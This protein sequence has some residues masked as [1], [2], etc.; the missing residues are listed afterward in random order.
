MAGRISQSTIETVRNSSDIIS[1]IGEYTKLERRA[2]NDYWG[3]CP[4]H[5]EKTASFHVDTDK[6]FYYCFGCHEHGDV[7]KFVMDM[8]KVSY[9]DAVTTL[10]RKSGITVQYEDGYVPTVKTDSVKLEEYVDLYERTASMFHYLLMETEMG[11]KGLEYIK[12]RGL[13]E[14]TIKKFKLGY[15]PQDRYWLHGFLKSKNYSD[16]FLAKSG[17][18]SSKYPKVTL[19]SDRLMFPIFNRNGKA[20]AFSGRVLHEQREGEGKYLNSPELP[21]YKKRETLFCFNFAKNSIRTNK[22]VIICEGNM[23]CIAYHQSGIDYAVAPLGTAFTDDQVKILQGF[24]DTIL[25]SFDSDAA[26]QKAT[27]KAI[28]M[29]RRHGLTVKIIQLKGGKDPA[30][31]LLNFGKE[32]LTAQVN[33]AILDSDYLLTRI[34]K[35]YPIDTPEGKS[36]AAL[37]F[38]PY[39]DSLQSEIQKESSLE[40]LCQAFNLK[41]EA[42]RRDFLNR[43]QAQGRIN[44]RSDNENN[45]EQNTPI[46]KN[47]ELRGLIAVTADLAQFE[48]LRSNL[49]ENDFQNP[50]AQRLFRILEECYQNKTFSEADILTACEGTGLAQ[51]ITQIIS[52]GVYQKENVRTV[53]EDTIKLINKNKI[54]KRRSD[55][56]KRIREFVVVTPEDEVERNNMILEKMN[57]DNQV[58]TINKK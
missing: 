57:L 54:D 26:G 25:L 49:C 42:V 33:N 8:D 40:Q 20:V 16:E 13:D 23:D 9:V 46:N 51:L 31:I 19:F 32:N 21:H 36:K 2:P 3:C 6:K 48:Y 5:G 52:T 15:A 38:F 4:F 18:F 11:K 53:I 35:M 14:E 12:A 7:I 55:L 1:I 44:N 39:I 28:M 24:V 47:A 27:I 43:N 41:P 56:V 50:D 34:G 58:K 10:A 22:K 29:C 37:D 30:E 17:M 45:K